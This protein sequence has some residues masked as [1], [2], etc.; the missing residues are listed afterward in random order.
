M[1]IER[2]KNSIRNTAAGLINRCINLLIPFVI[3][4]V[5]IKKLGSEFLGLSSLF[6]SII[7]VLNL[8]ELGVGS[9][10]IYNMYKPIAEDDTDTLAALLN[11]YKKVYRI[12]GL[13]IA[14]IGTALIPFLPWIVDTQELFGTGI[15][16][17][18]LYAIYLINTVISYLF[19]AYRKSLLTAYQRQDIISNI[20]SIVR[21][22]LYSSQLVV[23]FV[24]PNYYVYIILMPIFTI[25]DNILV[26]HVTKRM[27]AQT[28]KKTESTVELKGILTN[29]KYV[30]GHKIGAVIIQSADSIIISAFLSINLL[31][32]YSNYYYI[33]SALVGL[34]NVGFNA[35][36]ASVG[37]SIITKTKQQLYNLFSEL[38]FALFFIIAFCSSSLLCLYQPFMELWMGSEY[39]FPIKTVVLFVIYFYVWQIRVIS[40]CFKDAAGMW[41][42]D[43]LKPY[44]GILVNMLLNILLI[45]TIGIDGVIIATICVMAF[46]YSPW[47]TFVLH[48]KLFCVSSKKYVVR[49]VGYFFITI[50][51]SSIT[52]FATQQIAIDGV[53]GFI[54][55]TAVTCLSTF[56]LLL[57]AS[58]WFPEFK[59]LLKR[60]KRLWKKAI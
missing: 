59:S 34:I 42:D 25:L 33:I 8:A 48:K 49:E 2:T 38:S 56:I 58:F 41:K 39:L 10:L 7:Q 26:A 27:F 13:T 9:A 23:L 57:V 50:M 12:I 53:L 14:V 19:F 54:V 4:T 47:E 43:S 30:F 1:K 37:N 44:V 31:T 6:T 20:D 18:I 52:Y 45:Q 24:S 15:N 36:L 22:I 51:V 40:L 11:S 21:L 60:V 35:I 5:L 16:L 55:K 3:R 32:Q 46:I 28:L 17:Y 29:T